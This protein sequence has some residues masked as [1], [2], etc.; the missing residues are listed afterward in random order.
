MKIIYV[1]LF[2]LLCSGCGGYSSPMATAPQPGVVPAIAQLSPDNAS[3]GGPG[4]TLT[5]NGSKFGTNAV[6]KWNGTAQATMFVTANQLVATIPGTAIATPGTVPVTVTN[7][8]TPASGG[9]YGSGG[10]VSETSQAVDFTI[11]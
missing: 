5:V 10:T 4:L 11:Q 1:L 8:G 2:T 9:P 7:P 6:V 3:A